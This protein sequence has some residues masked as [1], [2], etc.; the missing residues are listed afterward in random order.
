ME[1]L[2]ECV[3]A[4]INDQKYILITFLRENIQK[5]TLQQMTNIYLFQNSYF[6]L[7]FIFFIY[8]KIHK[9]N[10]YVLVYYNKNFFI[11]ANN[12]IVKVK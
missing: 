9:L 8:L 1:W 4:R 3:N 5:G 2:V 12:A 11:Y 7:F 10:V 6:I